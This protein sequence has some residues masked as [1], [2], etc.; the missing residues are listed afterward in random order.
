MIF[1]VMSVFLGLIAPIEYLRM[2]DKIGRQS[3]PVITGLVSALILYSVLSFPIYSIIII[4]VAFIFFCWAR[5]LFSKN[6]LEVFD[7]VINSVS[8]V[9]LIT[10]PLCFL[11]YLYMKDEGTS[12]LGRH[13]LLYLITVTKSGDIFAYVVGM[14]S[15]KLLKGKNHKII[16]SISP[17]KSWEGTIGGL[18][19]SVIMSI[20]FW[21]L[22]EITGKDVY[23]V[24]IVVGVLLFLGG[25]FGD[26]A[27]SSLK[28]LCGIKDSGAIIPGIGGVLDL[29]DSLIINAPIFTIFC[30]YSF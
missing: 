29:L 25:F 3:Y 1:L 26:L 12:Y 30:L 8:A 14:S 20:I 9:F 15:N 5:I 28:R 13:L 23:F 16:P 21:N 17:K 19:G 4:I 18:L 22:L 7:A 11:G 24:P 6:S 10:L 27:E 2:I